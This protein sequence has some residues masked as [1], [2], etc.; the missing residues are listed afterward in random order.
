MS[1]ENTNQE[2]MTDEEK[3]FAALRQKA[4]AAE[5]RV[6][7][8]LP[9][10]I[11]SQ[12]RGAGLDPNSREGQ[13]L[14]DFAKDPSEIPGLVEKYGLSAQ[15]DSEAAASPAPQPNQSEQAQLDAAARQ[16]AVQSVA[17]STDGAPK[18]AAERVADANQRLHDP[19]LSRDEKRR[20]VQE[21]VS[22]GS[23]MLL[24]QLNAQR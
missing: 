20:A 6:N 13:M 22:A 16:Q 14:R 8:L 19:N 23:Q 17:S 5:A 11:E 4:E 15:E 10:A 7:E 24:E 18:T 12:I 21:Q 1:E 2:N 9:Y 3:N